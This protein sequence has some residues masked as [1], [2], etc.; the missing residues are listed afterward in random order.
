M[1][2]VA[3]DAN[4]E[5]DIM[6]SNWI[7]NT[8]ALIVL[9]SQALAVNH[10]AQ[11]SKAARPVFR[12]DLPNPT[13]DKPQSKVWFAHDFWWTCLPTSTGNQIWKRTPTGWI[14]TED[15]N[16]PVQELFGHGDVYAEL[17]RIHVAM[18]SAKAL[19]V[20]VMDYQDDCSGYRRAEPSAIWPFTK[21]GIV[22]TATI[23]KDETDHLWVAY[24][25][26]QSIWVRAS[27]GPTGAAWT[28]PIQLGTR[29]STDDICAIARL[30]GGV[31]VIWSNQHKDSLFFRF[32][33]NGDPPRQWGLTQV[34]AQ[35]N[36]TA[37]DHLNCAVTEDGTLYV[38]T[39]TSVDRLDKP[40]LS[41]RQRLPNGKW[42]SYP[43]ATLTPNAEPSRP[44]VLSC[45]PIGLLLCHT[46]YGKGKGNTG[47]NSISGIMSRGPNPD[48]KQK[49]A[50]LIH[51]TP[52]LNNVTGCKSSLP[53]NGTALL[54]ASDRQGNV[55]EAIV[56]VSDH[57][58]YEQ[59]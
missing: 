1:V 4:H 35:G 24:D 50:E 28:P 36:R 8:F 56:D 26:E 49:A 48:L 53:Q 52:H 33:Q 45:R 20:V 2:A 11:P 12:L 21:T 22:E 58:P 34:V 3:P 51:S 27:T 54:L 46:L 40:L 16:S 59:P 43:Y 6:T 31:G 32:H 55:Y 38:A 9:L 10:A 19:T 57:V 5:C 44:I 14:Q 37:D 17:D 23:T 41:L 29:T 15:F 39:K 18:V 47:I 42:H 25:A 13:A 7:L 30:P